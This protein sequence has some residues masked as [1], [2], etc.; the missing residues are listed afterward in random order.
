MS[1]K[2]LV[3]LAIALMLCLLSVSS[4]LAETGVGSTSS[5]TVDATVINFN[6]G[7]NGL[8]ISDMSYMLSDIDGNNVIN[9]L[10]KWYIASYLSRG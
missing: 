1:I 5:F 2:R 9:A 6:N 10:D 8:I 3:A 4:V 7:N